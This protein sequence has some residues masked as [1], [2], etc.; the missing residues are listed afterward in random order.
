MRTLET[1][2]TKALTMGILPI[3][4]HNHSLSIQKQQQFLKLQNV[5][6]H[7]QRIPNF[8]YLQN[9][10]MRSQNTELLLLDKVHALD[11]NLSP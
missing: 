6:H 7:V 9:K 3:S 10:N 11:K 2:S 1:A 5:K 4:H 8:L